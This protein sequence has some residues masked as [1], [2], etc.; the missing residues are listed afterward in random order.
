MLE[1]D[2]QYDYSFDVL[3]EQVSEEDLFEDKTHER[4]AETLNSLMTTTKNGLTIGLEGS[5]GS[6]KSTVINILRQKLLTNDKKVFFFAFDAWAHDGDPLRKI[7]LESLI[8]SI[9]PSQEDQKLNELKNEVSARKKTVNITTEKSASK[10]GKILSISAVFIPVGAALLTAVPYE[11]LLWPWHDSATTVNLILL[12]AL[13]FSSLPLMA[14]FF[15]GIF[16]EK[17]SSTGKIKWDFFE[18]QS[19][20]NYTQD[21]TEDG[22]RTSI[23]FE[24]FFNETLNYLFDTESRYQY[25]QAV[26]VIDNL[27][28]VDAEY[29]QTIWSTLQTFFQHKSSS[30]NSSDHEWKKKLWFLIPFDR[31]AI[32]KIWQSDSLE[33]KKS[34]VI[35]TSF[36]EKC[37]QITVEVSPSVM[38]AWIDY[39]KKC[40]DKSLCGWPEEF[41]KDYIESYIQC[42]SK[43]DDSPS[44]RRIHN[45]IN[46]AGILA[47][48]WKGEFSAE[49]LCIYSLAK[50]SLTEIEFRR[51]LINDGVPESFPTTQKVKKVKAE[52]AGI[53]FGVD[54]SKGMQL[55]LA[56][57]IKTSLSKGDGELLKSLESTHK[58]AFW[59][60]LRASSDDW[61]VKEIHDD[62]YKIDSITALHDAFIEN[63]DQLSQYIDRIEYAILNSFQELD[64]DTYSFSKVVIYL[65]EMSNDKKS[66]LESCKQQLQLRLDAFIKK[67]EFGGNELKH[68][69]ELKLL[70]ESEGVSLKTFHYFN[71]DYE[72]WSKW[73]QECESQKVKMKSVLPKKSI[74]K[75]I[76]EKCEFGNN[77]LNMASVDILNKTYTI[78]SD[79]SHWDSLIQSIINWLNLPS[80]DADAEPIYKLIINLLPRI[81]EKEELLLKEC[82]TGQEF[83]QRAVLSE[84]VNNPSLPF[85]VAILDID[86]RDKEHIP[87]FIKEYLSEELNEEMVI[88]AFEL[89]EK[90]NKLDVIW[91]LARDKDNIFAIQILEK[92]D[93]GAL[94]SCDARYVDEINWSSELILENIIIKLCDNG[95]IKNL[96]DG[97]KEDPQTYSK[98][99]YLINK[100]G[101]DS[102]KEM[103]MSILNSFDRKEWLKAFEN[104]NELLLCVPNDSSAFS[105]E[106]SDYF[107]KIVIG[108]IEE[109]EYNI[110]KSNFNLKDKVLDL[111]DVHLRD[112]TRKYFEFHEKDYLSEENFMLIAPLMKPYMKDIQQS[113]YEMKLNSWIDNV[114]TKKLEWFLNVDVSTQNE[115]LQ[116]LFATI[117]NKMQ[118][119]E[120]ETSKIYRNLNKKLDLG[121]RVRRSKNS[122]TTESNLK[123]VN[124]E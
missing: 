119:E 121:I 85:L 84:I 107:K 81:S 104:D 111:T 14:L 63:Y 94:F 4:V 27:D 55:L 39:F 58:D 33:G 122:K 10:L 59:L 1:E 45:T 115:P 102:A 118:L 96:E 106:W 2:V 54:A 42:M 23:E 123:V 30:L 48:H 88:W 91:E 62:K 43:L 37:F 89:F 32:Q 41:K 53:L 9:D 64:L 60:V 44:P 67:E 71:L 20:E 105:M 5:W 69:E 35:A 46:R 80:R 83:W 66:L 57:E 49:S 18:S 124:D 31:E 21:I 56:P 82:I 51:A 19:T 70:L 36:M 110:F 100:Y 11:D 109:P 38:S 92:I 101:S 65:F 103:V 108:E 93:N 120:N 26:I 97:I 117:K 75:E 78:S 76:I 90:T 86:F 6:G 74:Y 15:W 8:T 3:L 99:I 87:S 79:Y 116:M 40:V 98:V 68:L 52:L 7:F 61:I 13:I 22:E 77:A 17:D 12:F 112:I 24:R 50:Q 16:G 34:N 72:M 95:A 73:L 29:A 113:D 47:L 114:Y 25:E 28:R